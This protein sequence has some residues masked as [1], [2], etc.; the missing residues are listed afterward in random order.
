MQRE[1]KNKSPKGMFLETPSSFD[2]KRSNLV[3]SDSVYSS[4][5]ILT[6]QSISTLIFLY[7]SLTDSVKI[8]THDFVHSQDV[9]EENLPAQLCF[10]YDQT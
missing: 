3:V 4:F 7:V 5:I 1:T 2:S 6:I 8:T 9:M 10:S